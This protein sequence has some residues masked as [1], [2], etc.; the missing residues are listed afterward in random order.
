MVRAATKRLGALSLGLLATTLGGAA[1]AERTV[2][3]TPEITP[4]EVISHIAYLASDRLA[5]RKAGSPECAEAGHY[6]AGRFR[7]YGLTPAGEGRTFY[8]Y[9]EFPTGV[10]LREGNRLVLYLGGEER[11]GTVR[12]DFLP[13]AC[14][15]NA[16][17]KG[18]VVFAGYGIRAPELH[19]D[20]FAGLEVVG[21]IVLALR[22]GPEGNQ[23]AGR[24]GR[25]LSLRAKAQMA[26]QQGAAGVLFFTGTEQDEGQDLGGFRF[27]GRPAGGIP[28]A[29]I[30]RE[31][32]LA[33]L[34][35]STEQLTHWQNHIAAEVRKQASRPPR[36]RDGIRSLGVS[37]G[38]TAELSCNLE[39]IQSTTANILGTIEGSDP[40]LGQQIIC[41]GAHYDHVGSDGG[42]VFNGADDNASGTAGLLEV[43]QYFAAHRDATERTLLFAAFSGEEEGFLGSRWYLQHPTVP[44]EQIVAMLNLDMIGR[45][46]NGVVHIGGIRTS[47]TWAGLLGPTDSAGDLKVHT[48][49]GSLGDSDHEPFYQQNIPFLH[50]YTGLHSDYHRPTDDWEK[51]N[52][53]GEV[54]ILR[55]VV[56]VI[57]R[58][59][60]SPDRLAFTP[61]A[62]G[63]GKRPESY[64][65]PLQR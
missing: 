19:Y 2:A 30:R 29:V 25:Y 21:K 11:I 34:G 37:S 40:S 18:E 35:C 56:E 9:F 47:P 6:L 62:G 65:L 33:L 3:V 24:F 1:A 41:V 13:Q 20:D 46:S 16:T 51:I 58:L 44:L 50:F 39:A 54:Q 64:P 22:W 17:A 43:A 14:S 28:A 27:D 45:T 59:N 8:Q 57:R 26:Q 38:V 60:A 10:R 63:N 48:S 5:G 7:E 36:E 55:L 52:A 61:V 12:Q 49:P 4:D 23:P 53:A 15:A 31:W 42:P 32:G